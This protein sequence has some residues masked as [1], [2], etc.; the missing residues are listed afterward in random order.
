MK[1]MNILIIMAVFLI[2]TTQVAIAPATTTEFEDGCYCV[3]LVGDYYIS[4]A[5]FTAAPTPMNSVL[6]P[7]HLDVN[8]KVCKSGDDITVT[9]FNDVASTPGVVLDTCVVKIINENTIELFAN[10]TCMAG[11]YFEGNMVLVGSSGSYATLSPAP[12]TGFVN[13]VNPPLGI[14]PVTGCFTATVEECPE[15]EI[16]EFPTVAIPMLAIMG[17]AFVMQRRKD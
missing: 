10:G 11:N 12:A 5:L 14:I 7:F 6:P 17:L 1:I 16:P 13:M 8:A 2:A 15:Q 3:N 9:E 4:T